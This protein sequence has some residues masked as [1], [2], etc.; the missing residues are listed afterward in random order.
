LT[1][2]QIVSKERKLNKQN[3]LARV[4]NDVE[5]RVLTVASDPVRDGV[6]VTALAHVLVLNSLL[7]Q[8]LLFH[9]Q[10]DT[11]DDSRLAVAPIDQHRSLQN[12]Y[13]PPNPHQVLSV[14][15]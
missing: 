1:Y 11:R 7:L 15:T 13:P 3:Y 14:V 12:A 2:A 10:S 9:A 6:E 5:A 8:A 4:L